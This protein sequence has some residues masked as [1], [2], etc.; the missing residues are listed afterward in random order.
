[1]AGGNS[2]GGIYYHQNL[3]FQFPIDSIPEITS[4]PPSLRQQFVREVEFCWE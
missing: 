3:R 2:N 1:M 4:P